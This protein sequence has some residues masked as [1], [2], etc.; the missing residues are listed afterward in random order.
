MMGIRRDYEYSVGKNIQH[1]KKGYKDIEPGEIKGPNGVVCKRMAYPARD[2]PF[3]CI[4]SHRAESNPA[5][6]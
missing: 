1:N 6:N 2:M 5:L 4:Q 3:V